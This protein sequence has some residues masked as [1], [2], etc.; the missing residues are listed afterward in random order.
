ML[1]FIYEN[2]QSQV[3][4]CSEQG[5]PARA[6]GIAAKSPDQR[7]GVL[8]AIGRAGDRARAWAVPE[9]AGP[10]TERTKQLGAGAKQRHEA[11]HL[12]I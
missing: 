12:M 11:H 1:Y 8:D 3:Y 5:S 2:S 6:D 9:H 10:M 4:Y 7:E